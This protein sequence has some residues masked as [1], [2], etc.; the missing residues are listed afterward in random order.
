[1]NEI[2]FLY[3]DDLFSINLFIDNVIQNVYGDNNNFRNIEKLNLNTQDDISLFYSQ[4]LNL[5]LFSQKSILEIFLSPKLVK[6]L[7]K[8]VSD[9]VTYLKNIASYK[10]IIIIFNGDNFE[11][12]LKKQLFDSA[13]YE[14][15]HGFSEVKEFLKLKPWQ[16]ELMKDRVGLYAKKLNVTFDSNALNLFVECFKD[17]IDAVYNELSKLQLYLMPEN[18]ITEELISN[19]YD[20]SANTDVLFDALIFKQ[21]NGLTSIIDKMNSSLPF[22]YTLASLQNKLRQSLQIKSYSELSYNSN[23]ISKIT[24]IHLYRVGKELQRLK[25]ISQSYLNKLCLLLSKLEYNLKT[26]LL[27]EKN[28]LDVLVLEMENM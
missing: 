19:L 20:Q 18:K 8:N 10:T 28:A 5:S 6:Y 14:Q 27:N 24:G 22:L 2:Y 1:M 12:S 17:N 23:Q 25:S 16:T 3:G 9:F 15:I 13:F 4:G 26:G 11:K 21:K 7:N